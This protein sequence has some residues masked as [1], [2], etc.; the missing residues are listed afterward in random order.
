MTPLKSADDSFD[1][2]KRFAE[3]LRYKFTLGTSFIES[4]R[5]NY[6]AMHL[7]LSASG[8]SRGNR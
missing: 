7:H 6:L 8:D 1:I 4:Y 3:N 2:C 5:S